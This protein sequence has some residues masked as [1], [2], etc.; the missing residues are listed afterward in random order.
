MWNLHLYGISKVWLCVTNKYILEIF[1]RLESWRHK[2]PNAGINRPYA[3][4]H[5]AKFALLKVY[6][7]SNYMIILTMNLQIW[8]DDWYRGNCKEKVT[9]TDSGELW[10]CSRYEEW[11][12]SHRFFTLSV[13]QVCLVC[14]FNTTG[15]F[16]GVKDK[17][18][19]DKSW[20]FIFLLF[21]LLKIFAAFLLHDMSTWQ[22]YNLLQSK[23][24]I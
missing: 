5:F 16:Y 18:S 9:S 3:C 13:V 10:N 1:L 14:F 17:V 8:L 23:D 6:W 15:Y 4:L 11:I 12:M 21:Q 7:N 19:Q 22:F 24:S 2:L 20:K